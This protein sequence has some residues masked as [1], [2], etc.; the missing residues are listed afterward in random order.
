MPPVA[1][2]TVPP[3]PCQNMRCSAAT[4]ALMSRF[5]WVLRGR[6]FRPIVAIVAVILLGNSLYLLHVFNPNPLNLY[7]GLAAITHPGLT[8]G[9]PS[10]DPNS[11]ITSQALG[12]LAAE[13]WLH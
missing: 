10:A 1:Q 5:A 8:A 11:G 13:D 3:I 7:S 2:A 12:H 6:H 4:C 9:S